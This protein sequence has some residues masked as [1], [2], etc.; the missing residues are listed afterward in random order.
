MARMILSIIGD[1]SDAK[2]KIEGLKSDLA[3]LGKNPIKITV[4]ASGLDALS[5]QIAEISN[6]ASEIGNVGSTGSGIGNIASQFEKMA[7]SASKSTTKVTETYRVLNDGTKELLSTTTDFANE[8]GATMRKVEAAGQ[9]ATQSYTLDLQ[10]RTAAERKAE[11]DYQ[12]Y[13]Q[14][15]AKARTEAAAE[16]QRQE[17]AMWNQ[18]RSR[19]AEEEASVESRTQKE[20]A[21]W[22]K[23]ESAREAAEQKA[24]DAADKQAAVNRRTADSLDQMA[25]ASGRAVDGLGQLVSTQETMRDGNVIR[26]VDTYK[27]A[28]GNVS[29]VITE[30]DSKTGELTQTVQKYSSST[31]EATKNHTLLGDSLT[32]I[33]AKMA[34][35]QILGTSIATV[36]RS[37][38]EALS[39]MKEVDSEL[40]TVRKVTGFT[41]DEMA[42]V[43]E[44]AYKTASA[45]GVAANEY[46]ES[47]AAFAR[48]GYKEQSESLAELSTKTQIVGDTTAEVANQ[49]LLSVDAAYKYEGSIESLSRVL[50][51][52]N[53]LDNNYATSIEKIA[54]GM[55]IVAPVAAQMHVTVD[56][57]AA[58]IGTI[59]AVTQRSGSEAARALR[60]LFLNIA[61]DTK[62]EIDEGVTWTTG[63]IEGL[64][65]VIRL[66]A[67]DAWDAAQASEG[68]IDPMKAMEGLAKSME[69]GVLSEQKLIEMVSDIGGKLRTS[70]L[71]AIIQNWDMYSEMLDSF[72]D[73][74]GSADKEVEN[75]LDSWE[76]KSA[77]LSNAWT[78]FLSH[79]IDVDDI[80]NALEGVTSVIEKLDTESGH[81][82]IEVGLLAT[83]FGLLVH[84]L[85]GATAKFAAFLTTA[86]A[87][88]GIFADLAA[89]IALVAE[90]V[91]GSV[92][93]GLGIMGAVA[94]T[95]V[96]GVVAVVDDVKQLE[97][98]GKIGEGH[99]LE[100]YTANVEACRQEV[101]RLREQYEA[102]S[103]AGADLTSAQY[104]LDHATIALANAEKELDKQYE[105]TT[106]RRSDGMMTMDEWNAMLDAEYERD[107]KA[108]E[109]AEAHAEANREMVS[110]MVE[111]L[112][113]L[114]D[115]LESAKAA[116]EAFG[117]ATETEKGDTFTAY[118]GIYEQFLEAWEDGLHGSNTVKAAIEAILGPEVIAEYAGD[119][120]AL[121]ELLA[122]DF[123]RGVF[124]EGGED[125]GVAFMNSLSEIANEYGNVV[126][127]NG[128]VVAS[129]EEVDGALA[130]T[131]YDL[132]GLA[133]MLGTTPDLLMSLIDAWDIWSGGILTSREELLGLADALGALNGTN[134]VDVTEFLNGLVEAGNTQSEIWDLYNALTE[135]GGV[136]LSNVPED[137]AGIISQAE[138]S[139]EKT[140]EATDALS[141]LGEENAEPT[142]ELDTTKFDTGVQY[143]E[144]TLKRLSETP[145][146][147]TVTT[148][149]IPGEAGGTDF[150]E[151]GP[152][153]VNE[154]GPEIIQE[155]GTARIAGGGKP[156][157]TNVER[158][159][160]IFTAEETEQI[161]SGYSSLRYFHAAAMG[162]GLTDTG[163]GNRSAG[164]TRTSAAGPL[165]RTYYGSNYTAAANTAAATAQAAA[166]AADATSAIEDAQKEIEDRYKT[167]LDL[168][169]S[170][171]ELMEKQGASAEE[172]A[173]KITEIQN[174]L[175][176][177]AEELRGIGASET[178]IN[179]L[180]AEWW[181]YLEDKQNAFIDEYEDAIKLKKSE[182]SLMEAQGVSEDERAAK[183][184]EIQGL[185]HEEAEYMR[186]I[187]YSQAEINGLSE[188]W[189]DL[190]KEKIELLT[191]ETEKRANI[192]TLREA[193]LS[194]LEASG[195]SEWER[196]SKMRE[197]QNA[198]H[199]EAE[200]VRATAA[201]QEAI[202][203]Q[204]EDETKLTDEQVALLNRVTGLSTEWW[205]Y[206]GRITD[207]LEES[208]DTLERITERYEELSEHYTSLLD[209]AEESRVSALQEELDLLKAQKDEID[210]AREEEEK[211]LAVEK[212]RIAIENAQKERNV[213]QY[214]AAT[215]QWE[216]VANAQTVAKAQEDLANAEQ[217]LDDFYRDRSIKALE[218]NIKTIQTSYDDLRDAIKEFV[219]GIKDGTL[220]FTDA[221]SFFTTRFAG[222]SLAGLAGAVGNSFLNAGR[223]TVLDKMKANSAAWFN[224]DEKT[225]QDL[226]NQNYALGT[227]QGWHRGDDGVWYDSS[228]RRVYD[229]G[230]IL[231]GVGGVKATRGDEMI[232]PPGITSQLL[233]AER[234][235]AFDAFLGH[236]GIVTAAA[237]GYAGFSG[238]ITQSRIG[239]QMNG[240]S[241]SFGNITLSENQA[242][243][244]TVYDL[245][246]MA[247]GLSL[248]SVS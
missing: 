34:A 55:G 67:K 170:Q 158:G 115:E 56:E 66:Y 126:D 89:G 141:D 15:E 208:D 106:K 233:T 127:E 36:I 210:D 103:D 183:I 244:M 148:Q 240:D 27:D 83:A 71:L 230:G 49:F 190:Q 31:E 51:G 6:A 18:Y 11:N 133:D 216:W 120:E 92:A 161:L 26:A 23:I 223:E 150:A 196:V 50:D 78:Q 64:R 30:V 152:T 232:L 97:T 20:I 137:I 72:S 155:G 199:D 121:G 179:K 81:A 119:W 144:D 248:H 52:A 111:D 204:Q 33:I 131:G 109:A 178:D 203:Q 135:I 224:A 12:T 174:T 117:K 95:A 24:E 80:K 163:S 165:A 25:T 175:H 17:D 222:T 99:S 47:V 105:K 243:G 162:R 13:L 61:G 195:A 124:A 200:A 242:R 68:I 221:I 107:K 151:G 177:E 157:I 10:K 228:G 2:S 38:K 246:Q 62:T 5:R 238:S 173:A 159:A 76:R 156:T 211:L 69:E 202:R 187:G 172:R 88:T 206:Q 102:L 168:L 90:A 75:A 3:E 226:A 22:E 48:A 84:T 41:A 114:E 74:V 8:Y 98:E 86:G 94:A 82:V 53:E 91:G 217:A 40:V 181:D 219:K 218:E 70:Q 14:N 46:L 44:Q 209:E 112:L 180:S 149:E 59:T 104:E 77:Q 207:L 229:S 19:L 113:T 197:I 139:K 198:L 29:K 42:R 125:H 87:G 129:F 227:A 237:N 108:A 37:F 134:T 247:R 215:G 212:A 146:N 235:G 4:E 171:L 154:E 239:T 184:G 57:L 234:N 122:S 118:A 164:L 132:D 21:E 193:E 28:L 138:T 32:N 140:D 201:Y 79:I 58:S 153:L 186:S 110:S 185:L 192:V 245:A 160:R 128:R 142:V 220:S 96:A 100:E 205:K 123:W 9:E 182:L 7:D 1:N 85:S 166:A 45:Y 130:L 39:T 236:L 54:E 63:E 145:T 73:S 213:R 43:E 191:I 93:A 65:D 231:R 101:E 188:E 35:W 189:L 60:A 176:L 167:E 136:N 194:F 116:I 16:R 169:K 214:N 143:V 147:I 225:R 241:Y